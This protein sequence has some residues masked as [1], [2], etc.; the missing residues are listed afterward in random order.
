VRHTSLSCST[1]LDM[2]TTS[3]CPLL[4]TQRQQL[5]QDRLLY[6]PCHTCQTVYM[7]DYLLFKMH[8]PVSTSNTSVAP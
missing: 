7:L 8:S 4:H 6:L 5:T 3:G 1:C 2:A